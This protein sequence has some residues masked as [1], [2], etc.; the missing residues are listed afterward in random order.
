[1]GNHHYRSSSEALETLL[2]RLERVTRAGW[3]R[4]RACCPDCGSSNPSTLS[5][6]DRDGFPAC[7]CFKC[8]ADTA[9]VIEA[10][11][12]TW[13][14]LFH[15][16]KRQYSPPVRVE[17]PKAPNADQQAKLERLWQSC[18]PI[19]SGDE[20]DRYLEGRGLC[21]KAWV[22]VHVSSLRHHPALE[23]WHTPEGRDTPELLGHYPAMVAQVKHPTFGLV[24]LHRTY[25]HPQ[26]QGKAEVPS[27]KKL[28]KPVFEGAVN[29]AAIR[30]HNP[31][32]RLALA[33]GIETALAVHLA[34]SWPVWATVSAGGMARV[35]LPPSVGEVLI[36]ADHDRAGLDAAHE[37]ASRLRGQGRRV[38]V[39][40][41]PEAG[42]DWLD[43]LG[44]V[45]ILQV[46]RPFQL[47]RYLV[48]SFGSL[49]V[50]GSLGCD[51]NPE[52]SGAQKT[53]LVHSFPR[54]QGGSEP[55]TKIR[56][57]PWRKGGGE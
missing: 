47:P 4:H 55:N 48:Q 46:A 52:P 50:F 42:M 43:L 9:A 51:P 23:Y 35:E 18:R 16:T 45:N 17:A 2:T 56:P 12:L 31:T 14:E 57:L 25:L 38:Q 15:G 13:R 20:V 5:I 3:D 24:A 11:G 1:M 19:Q 40:T 10:V 28:T 44:R 6:I 27:P 53:Y 34:S 26:G 36:A 32:E 22:N 29:G 33:E 8:G 54:S 41:P 39:A 7:H 21:A 49:G 37:L 30:L